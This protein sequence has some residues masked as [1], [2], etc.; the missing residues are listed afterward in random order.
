[1]TIKS[2][3]MFAKSLIFPKT[4]KKSSA[5]R[6]LFGALICIGLSIVPLI[7]VLSVATGIIDGMTERII[8]L[9]SNHL[10]A[11]VAPNILSVQSPEKF[12]E[13]AQSFK[14]VDGVLESYPEINLSALASAN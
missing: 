13:Y 3:L 6:S 11:Y 1:M 12:K 9:S 4:E 14:K 2:S 8:G 10:Q 5:R 7:V